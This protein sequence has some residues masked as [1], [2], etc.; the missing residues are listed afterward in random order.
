[1]R[2]AAL[3]LAVLMSATAP[4]FAQTARPAAQTEGA[5]TPPRSALSS[6]MPT[7]AE[8]TALL[9]AVAAD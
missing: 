8:D 2:L 7:F 4:A 1:M 5:W 3:G 9:T 6:A